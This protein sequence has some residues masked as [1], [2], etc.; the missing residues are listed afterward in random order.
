M[1]KLGFEP[2]NPKGTAL[3]AVGF[4]RIIFMELLICGLIQKIIIDRFP[5]HAFY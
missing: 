4:I 3:K 5:T 1:H 2:R